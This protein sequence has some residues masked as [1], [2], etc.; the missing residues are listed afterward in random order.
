MDEVTEVDY[1]V[2]FNRS[3]TYDSFLVAL[4]GYDVLN[5]FE[6][7]STPAQNKVEFT[8]PR[9]IIRKFEKFRKRFSIKNCIFH[10]DTITTTTI[11]K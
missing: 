3:V 9:E 7:R 10:L 6:T 11:Y 5:D 8:L 2:E 1:T 4:A